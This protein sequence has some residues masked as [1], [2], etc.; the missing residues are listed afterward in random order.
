MTVDYTSA[1]QLTKA[2]EVLEQSLQSRASLGMGSLF[3]RINLS[4]VCIVLAQ[5]ETHDDK[6]MEYV[7]QGLT[8]LMQCDTSE[9]G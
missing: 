4:N 1:L 6:K 3:P 8:C 7:D 5:K 9:I 2:K